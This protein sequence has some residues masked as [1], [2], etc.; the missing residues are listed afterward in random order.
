MATVDDNNDGDANK[1]TIILAAP[2]SKETTCACGARP[3]GG[4]DDTTATG[5]SSSARRDVQWLRAA[6]LGASDG[7]VSTAALMLGVGAARPVGGGDDDDLRAV[8]LAGLA[9]LVAGACSMA[10]GEYV[11]V[12]AQLDVEL[13]ELERVGVAAGAGGGGGGRAAGL[14]SPGQAAAASALAFAS[15]AAVP[16]LAAWFVTGY[17]ARVAVVVATATATLAVFGSLGAVLGR[18]P[19]GRAGLRAVVGGL[20]AMGITYGLMKLF[21]IRHGV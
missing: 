11:S 13:A 16:L 15:G 5:M 18:A 9:G 4:D 14:P 1:L 7:L 17:R 2:G 6:V 19:G 20:V 3:T 12:H 10:I 8:L 21:R